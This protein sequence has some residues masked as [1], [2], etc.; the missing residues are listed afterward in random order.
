MSLFVSKK[1]QEISIVLDIGSASI[2]GS[3]VLF[4]QGHVPSVLYSNRLAIPIQEDVTGS[5][6]VSA[7]L[8]VLDNVVS[9]IVKKGLLHTKFIRMQNKSIHQVT[10]VYSSPWFASEAHTI[11]LHEKTPILLTEHYLYNLLTKEREDFENKLEIKEKVI[12]IEQKIT[13]TLLNGYVTTKPQNKKARDVEIS[14]F[15]SV[16]PQDMSQKIENLV[17]K[18]V[19]PKKIV[20]HSFSLAAYRTITNI[21]PADSNSCI[22]DISGEITDISVITNDVITQTATIPYGRNT[23]IRALTDKEGEFYA[24]ELSML[25][26]YAAGTLDKG[27][28]DKIEKKI[29]PILETWQEK[30]TPYISQE[31]TIF[32]TGDVGVVNIF[33]KKLS[34]LGCKIIMLE[35][36]HFEDVVSFRKGVTGDPFV[37]ISVSFVNNNFQLKS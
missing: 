16:I 21:F 8:Q 29:T 19:Q 23:L 4:S 13:Q 1:K 25:Q 36:G 11:S 35:A 32:V 15:I 31:K 3:L 6:Y 10:C 27:R 24:A 34:E 12:L 33:M 9:D 7:M 37:A 30:I 18:H 28:I 2:G 22:I 14:T 26:M 20:H 5:R 17:H